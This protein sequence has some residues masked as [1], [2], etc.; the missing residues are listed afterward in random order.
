M[1]SI[2]FAS[3]ASLSEAATAECETLV[4]PNGFT[5]AAPFDV[6]LACDATKG[7]VAM[8][9]SAD[10]AP[11]TDAT[12]KTACCVAAP[13]CSTTYINNGLTATGK[14]ACDNAKE[15][16]PADAKCLS[17][18]DGSATCDDTAAVVVE[19]KKACCKQKCTTGFQLFAGT[20]AGLEKCPDGD[21]IVST[22]SYCASGTCGAGDQT[23]CC[24]RKCTAGVKLF[25][26]ALGTTK[27]A[28]V[29]CADGVDKIATDKYCK[30]ATCAATDTQCCLQKCSDGYEL[31][32]GTTSGKRQCGKN[33]RV[34]PDS[35][36]VGPTCASA[37]D[38]TCCETK[39]NEASTDMAGWELFGGTTA[40]KQ[41][42]AKDLKVHETEYC[43]SQDCKKSTDSG[44]CCQQKCSAGFKLKGATGT[45]TECGE[46]LTVHATAYC[47]G[48]ACSSSDSGTCCQAMCKDQFK[49]D[50][51][52]TDEAQT[53]AKKTTVSEDG[54]CAGSP[55]VGSTDAAF[56]CNQMCKEMFKVKGGTGT[57]KLECSTGETISATA[58]CVGDCSADDSTACCMKAN[59]SST[60]AG[61][62]TMMLSSA[63]LGS[64]VLAY[65]M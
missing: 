12:K 7:A 35:F 19:D 45:G 42:C 38:K 62:A 3:L 39:C 23:T 56:C 6:D 48:A 8:I 49:A 46:G 64:M 65:S 30:T 33:E 20:T 22:S 47:K 60:T 44:T 5:K 31:F 36:C 24:A 54:K 26:E 58:Y 4:R 14:T 63:A 15:E 50:G 2:V 32:G 17:K 41:Q 29:N 59:N 21:Y 10:P 40:G 18:K 13:L 37:D 43:D 25:G 34:S 61:A 11:T 16:V 57:Q 55:C 9:T 51:A 1:R 53:C 28:N 52:T 27:P